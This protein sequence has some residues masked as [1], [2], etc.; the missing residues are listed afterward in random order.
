MK[1][2]PFEEKKGLL[3]VFQIDHLSG[4]EAGWVLES[5]T[6]PGLRNRQLISSM[7]KKGRPG[8]LLLLDIDPAQE[9][10]VVQRLAEHL[11]VFG[12]H[13]LP[14]Q[15]FFQRGIIEQVIV[16]LRARN[17]RAL[18]ATVRCRTT[19]IGTTRRTFF[20][21]DDLLNLQQR[22]QRE[23]DVKTA[24]L[25]LKQRLEKAYIGEIRERIEIEL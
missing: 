21:S 16:N 15:H 20:E 13:R 9:E 18:E 1:Q 7:T 5:E 12:Y 4:E 25:E 19:M 3:L 6:I 23:L 10:I 22:A 24:L 17:G 11:P 14:T 2:M 8:Y